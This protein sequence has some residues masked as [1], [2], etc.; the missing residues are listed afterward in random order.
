MSKLLLSLILL[1]SGQSVFAHAFLETSTPENGATVDAPE[2]LVLTFGEAVE[3]MFSVFELHPV[4]VPEDA[5][6]DALAAIAN[7]LMTTHF[8]LGLDSVIETTL[9]TEDQNAEVVL[10]L[11]PLEPGAYALMWRILS[12]DTHTS[13]DFITFVVQAS[14]E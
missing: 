5:D 13:Q 8:N 14:T 3:T 10:E 9:V 11:P 7:G 6:S 2:Q 4:D 1:I 12:V